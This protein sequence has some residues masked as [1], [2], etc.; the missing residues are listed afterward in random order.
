VPVK[1]FPPL[2]SMAG[3][4]AVRYFKGKP[5]FAGAGWASQVQIVMGADPITSDERRHQRALEGRGGGC[6]R[7]LR[8]KPVAA[9]APIVRGD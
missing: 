2:F 4:N 9:N 8:H 7:C 1:I 5:G 3:A 6:S